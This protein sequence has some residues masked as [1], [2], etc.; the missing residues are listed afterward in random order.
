M[1]TGQS[2]HPRPPFRSLLFSSECQ[3]TF[4]R[5]TTNHYLLLLRIIPPA[6]DRRRPSRTVLQTHHQTYRESIG[7]RL[8]GQVAVGRL[9]LV[10]VGDAKSRSF[11]DCFCL[12]GLVCVCALLCVCK[13]TTFQHSSNLMTDWTESAKHEQPQNQEDS[14]Q[15]IEQHHHRSSR[16]GE[17]VEDIGL[18]K[19]YYHMIT[20]VLF[21]MVQTV[22]ELFVLFKAIE[23][24][25]LV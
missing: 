14:T 9:K 4:W 11:F 1:P 15:P 6:E 12:V 19:Y 23:F 16:V 7:E 25:D 8:A 10:A 3:N 17:E 13:T 20:R 5:I 18:T 21:K 24:D 22:I 2:S